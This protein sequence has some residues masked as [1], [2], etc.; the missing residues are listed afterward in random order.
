MTS[1]PASS[2]ESASFHLLDQRIQRWIWSCGWTELRDAQERA[3]PLI[4]DGASDVLIAATT[5]SGKTEAAFFP[6]LT[7]LA[8]PSQPPAIALYVSPLKALIN[9]QW[10]RL[11]ELAG[12]L[13]VPVTPWHG[14]INR[15][16]KSHFTKK[17]EGCLL[18]TPESL[19]A[20]LLRH[21][22]GLADL[23]SGLRYVV[24]DELH[25]F[26][27]SER[28]KQLQSLLC[29]VEKVLGRRVCRIGLSATLGDMDGAAQFLRPDGQC[30]VAL[31][32][33]HEAGQELKVL[34]KAV[35]K[36]LPP[37]RDEPFDPKCPASEM[38][39]EHLFQ[40][41][42]G[43]SNLVF[44]GCRADVEYYSDRLRQ[45][46]EMEGFPNEF[47]PHH[48]NL[49]REIRE[50]TEAALKQTER[51][52]TAICTTTLELGI[53]V[54]PV[55]S[56]AQVGPP[57]SV[58]SLRQRLGR[59][60]RRPGEAMVLRAYC[61][62]PQLA[63][64]SA[65]SDQLRQGLVQTIAMIRLLVAGWYEPVDIHQIHASTLVQ[66]ILSAIAQH[67]GIAVRQLWELL[68]E[69]GPFSAVSKAHFLS[70]LRNLEQEEILFQDATGLLLLAPKG[71]RVTQH[72]SFY[73]AFRADEEYRVVAGER[74][75]GSLPISR[76][77]MPGGLVIFA[78]RRWQVLKV[79]ER[80]RLIEVRPAGGGAL[81]PF[82]TSMCGVVH[83]RVR[84]EM[85]EVL[86][87]D[88]PVPYLD[89]TGQ[90]LL[91]EA[92][93]NYTR[94][95]LEHNRILASGSQTQIFL[96]RGDRVNDTLALM[97]LDHGLKGVNEGLYVS[98][99]DSNVG[100]VRKVLNELRGE[101]AGTPDSLAKKVK[102]KLR[103]KWD[104][105]LPPELL[106][107]SFASTYIDVDGAKE[108]L[109]VFSI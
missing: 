79:C 78:G 72:Y 39:A 4:L 24:V 64:D 21:G 25:A 83:D 109:E 70:L 106:N 87:A 86:R 94:L 51:P 84:Q 10:R 29:R 17:P 71:E 101:K 85:R 9:D 54:G 103:E 34:V 66:Q 65:L 14:D 95:D 28:G 88:T 47:W 53:D 6:I 73:A 68:G 108:A 12:L 55:K 48:G 50:E 57:H 49:S 2:Y 97:L 61:V 93:E 77:L 56:V 13:E 105:L 30:P 35:L 5:A 99:T 89:D 107:A 58:A 62:E 42:R 32:A 59:S 100:R 33:S 92:R 3:I 63:A 20:L 19:E 36:P 76:L 40:V 15:Q 26:L 8:A 90:Q 91:R 81:P 38:V 69:A 18:I 22:H 82:H 27:G 7:R 23:L 31:V 60:G 74:T 45:R 11:E 16:R 98:V 104:L 80:Q 37:R 102:N 96:W 67:G 46:C 75:L 52:A 41:L 44:P 43:T 1:S